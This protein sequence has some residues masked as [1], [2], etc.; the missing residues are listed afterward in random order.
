MLTKS[1]SMFV[2][3]LN[4]IYN[5]VINIFTVKFALI[6]WLIVMLIKRNA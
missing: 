4:I 2:K 1:I 5:E 6:I 3:Y